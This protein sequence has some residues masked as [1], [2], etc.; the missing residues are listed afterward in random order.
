LDETEDKVPKE[1]TPEKK[2]IIIAL[3][4]GALAAAFAF[5]LISAKESR[6]EAEVKPVKVM[7]A[8]KYIPALSVIDREAVEFGEVPAKYLSG[9]NA[10][11]FNEI[12]NKVTLV[13]FL[14]GEAI[15]LNKIAQKEAELN[16]AIPAGMRAISVAVDEESG[17]GY[18]VKPGDYVDVL[19]TFDMTGGKSGYNATATILQA[20]RVISA[21]RNSSG[22]YAEDG[23][24]TL[25]L[26]LTPQ[27]AETITFAREKGK[28]SFSLRPIGD[29][30]REKIRTVVFSDLMKQSKESQVNEVEDEGEEIFKKREE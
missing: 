24:R 29:R 12:K 15:L 14:K 6:L 23:Y 18:M 7:V 8:A 10:V 9:A 25:T 28:L 16:T 3:V 26:A 27:E 17:V 30:G 2:I 20:A 1:I 11:D 5:L 21:G 19:L 4:S 22:A 13:P